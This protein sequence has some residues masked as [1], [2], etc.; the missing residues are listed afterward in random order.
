VAR[1]VARLYESTRLSSCPLPLYGTW[2]EWRAFPDYTSTIEFFCMKTCTLS[3]QRLQSPYSVGTTC[4]PTQ[5]CPYVS[6][7]SK[8]RSAY[9]KDLLTLRSVS[10]GHGACRT[11]VQNSHL[12]AKTCNNVCNLLNVALQISVLVCNGTKIHKWQQ[13][14][15]APQIVFEFWNPSPKLLR[16]CPSGDRHCQSHH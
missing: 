16:A 15:R 12:Q 2:A 7:V 9:C 14:G 11:T 4:R 5:R 8:R 3:A 10:I 1:V 13:A 6:P